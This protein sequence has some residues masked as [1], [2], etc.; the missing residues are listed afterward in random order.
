M[1]IPSIHEQTRTRLLLNYEQMAELVE[2]GISGDGI[3]AMVN[4]EGMIVKEEKGSQ[5]FEDTLQGVMKFRALY[6]T[7][8]GCRVR[9]SVFI[10]IQYQYETVLILILKPRT[11][12]DIL[13]NIEY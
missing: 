8:K 5:P 2:S 1:V 7:E 12:I 6:R 11:H 9:S 3:F 10:H 4:A 13:L